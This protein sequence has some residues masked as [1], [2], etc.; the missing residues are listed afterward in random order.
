LYGI[1][2]RS[3]R[4][5]P[6]LAG[7]TRTNTATPTVASCWLAAYSA[8]LANIGTALLSS[9]VNLEIQQGELATMTAYFMG[10]EG[11]VRDDR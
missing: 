5:T 8:A 9:G 3:V 10:K 2:T 11:G 6:S 7:A 4:L 1:L